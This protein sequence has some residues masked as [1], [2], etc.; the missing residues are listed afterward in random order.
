MQ[1][2]IYIYIDIF[3]KMSIGES[4]KIIPKYEKKMCLNIY[5]LKRKKI[6]LAKFLL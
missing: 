6:F 1:G 5:E 4:L 2:N 3:L